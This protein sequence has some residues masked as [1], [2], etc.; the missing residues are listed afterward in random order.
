MEIQVPE[1]VYLQTRKLKRNEHFKRVEER[2][3]RL[4]ELSAAGDADSEEDNDDFSAPSFGQKKD[5]YAD[6]DDKT[7]AFN[8]N[9]QSQRSLS[10]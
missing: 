6:G 10:S 9:L 1:L 7:G 5:P 8:P 3:A 2:Q 4:S